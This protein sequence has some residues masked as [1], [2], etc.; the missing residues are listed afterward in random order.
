M[1]RPSNGGLTHLERRLVEE[2]PVDW[3]VNQAAIRAG[4]SAKTAFAAGVQVLKRP[5]VQAALK[6]ALAPQQ[7]ENR[8]TGEWVLSRIEHIAAICSDDEGKHFK[9]AIA[10]KATKQLGQY[11]KLFTEK[12]EINVRTDLG[13]K[14]MGARNRA[15]LKAT[16]VHHIDAKTG[17]ETT[18]RTLEI[19][20]DDAENLLS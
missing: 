19:T 12:I 6:K 2:L 5:E 1:S 10:L 17:D 4:Y 11:H 3:N 18:T 14:I 7:T 15:K 8:R 13:N 20:T 9:P 16:E